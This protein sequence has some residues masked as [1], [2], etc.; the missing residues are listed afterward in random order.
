MRDRVIIKPLTCD[1]C[2]KPIT[3]GQEAKMIEFETEQRRLIV[4]SRNH[5]KDGKTCLSIFREA[6][7]DFG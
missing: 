1:V 2:K 7:R 4:H 6:L 3:L 5:Y